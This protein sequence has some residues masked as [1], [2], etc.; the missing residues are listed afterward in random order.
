[1]AVSAESVHRESS[2]REVRRGRTYVTKYIVRSV[3]EITLARFERR[4]RSVAK[5]PRA[6]GQRTRRLFIAVGG[7]GADRNEKL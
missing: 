5:I 4:A 2:A 7:G 1:M 3:M 6:P